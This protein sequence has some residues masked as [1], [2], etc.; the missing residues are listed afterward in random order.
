MSA[1]YLLVV[2]VSPILNIRDAALLMGTGGTESP[3]AINRALYAGPGW[4]RLGFIKNDTVEVLAGQT[5]D[6]RGRVLYPVFLRHPQFSWYQPFYRSTGQSMP[7]ASPPGTI[8]PISGIYTEAYCRARGYDPAEEGYIG[9]YFCN[10][11]R[12]RWIAHHNDRSL[13]WPF[14]SEVV[15]LLANATD[16]VPD[17]VAPDAARDLAAPA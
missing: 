14:L 6:Y 8:W 1:D 16:V 11:K 3:E 13:L 4:R 2:N 15:G 12:Q 10:P 9:K 7:A 5:I 17:I